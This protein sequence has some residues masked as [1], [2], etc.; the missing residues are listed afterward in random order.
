MPNIQYSAQPTATSYLS[1]RRAITYHET[2]P[3]P[4][5]SPTETAPSI[6][7]DEPSPN[8][9]NRGPRKSVKFPDNSNP[10]H[11]GA[12]QLLDPWTIDAKS[13][14]LLSKGIDTAPLIESRVD[15]S[16]AASVIC[17]YVII[18]RECNGD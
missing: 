16:A 7:I 4:T 6:A 14:M 9:Y 8:I 3:T 10:A 18:P 13:P 15:P 12:E 11:N 2:R 17:N 5:Q 1:T